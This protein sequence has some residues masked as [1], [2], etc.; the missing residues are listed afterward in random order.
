MEKPQQ[1]VNIDK[2]F[3]ENR[4]VELEGYLDSYEI[5]IR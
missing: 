3:Q 2:L 4:F 5:N 1:E